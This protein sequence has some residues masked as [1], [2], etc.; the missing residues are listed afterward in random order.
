[1][2]GKRF[3]TMYIAGILAVSVLMPAAPADAVVL[4]P[5]E[6]KAVY[7]GVTYF[8]KAINFNAD[9]E[10]TSVD[11]P[12]GTRT[13]EVP[14]KLDNKKVIRFKFDRLKTNE[15]IENVKKIVLSKNIRPYQFT[16]ESIE[17]GRSWLI[18][19]V[20]LWKFIN[21]EKI[22][23]AAG[24]KYLKA[25]DGVLYD[26]GMK[27][28]LHYPKNKK[29]AEY[30]MPS[31]IEKSSVISNGNLG[32]ITFS[33]NKKFIEV[34]AGDG[35]KKLKSIYFPDNIKY[36][37]GFYDCEKLTTIRWSKKMVSV[38]GFSNCRALKKVKLPDSVKVIEQESFRYCDNLQ[39][40]ILPKGLREI[41]VDA[42]AGCGKLKKI[43][44]LPETVAIVGEGAFSKVPGMKKIKKAPWLLSTKDSRIEGK[45]EFYS[46]GNPSYIAV[47]EVKKGRKNR[48][49]DSQVVQG[50]RSSAN[51]VT[52][53]RGKKKTLSIIPLVMNEGYKKGWKMKTNILKFTSSD[54]KVAKVTAN[55]KII[56]KKKGTAVITVK[57]RT[58]DVKRKIKVTV[59]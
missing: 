10:I 34:M 17:T 31:S 8:Y 12:E 38:E 4:V 50:L 43:S 32:S 9:L 11:V 53:G 26:A 42:F 52:L 1:M 39:E 22:E 37:E 41:H 45:I 20:D 44:S 16:D 59:K 27:Y 15:G 18:E 57:M 55:G 48:Y 24:N 3:I 47:A 19:E 29:A 33:K 51:K 30:K 46:N 25:V 56:G 13:L 40:V 28:L 35:C 36:V 6:G 7:K 2:R 21:L 5:E 58:S 23:V 49:Y 54:P 14:A